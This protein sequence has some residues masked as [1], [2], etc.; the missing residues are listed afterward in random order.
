MVIWLLLGNFLPIFF[1]FCCWIIIIIIGPKKNL[2][3]IYT[4]KKISCK[5]KN[6]KEPSHWPKSNSLLPWPPAKTLAEKLQVYYLHNKSL[7]TLVLCTWWTNE[8]ERGMHVCMNIIKTKDWRQKEFFTKFSRNAWSQ[9][10]QQN[11]FQLKNKKI[12]NK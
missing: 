8:W 4:I 2:K 9:W 3:Q 5:K 12:N 11:T 10:W 6:L 1:Q 7:I